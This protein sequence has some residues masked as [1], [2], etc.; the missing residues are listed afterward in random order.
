LRELSKRGNNIAASRSWRIIFP[1]IKG[2]PKEREQAAAAILARRFILPIF[3]VSY[4]KL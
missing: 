2:L 3:I 1:R 4:A